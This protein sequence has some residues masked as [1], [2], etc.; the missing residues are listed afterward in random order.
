[1]EVNEKMIKNDSSPLKVEGK[2][3]WCE[4]RK[5]IITDGAYVYCSNNCKNEFHKN[6]QKAIEDMNDV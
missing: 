2:C 4:K 5:A 6:A 1:M 3:D